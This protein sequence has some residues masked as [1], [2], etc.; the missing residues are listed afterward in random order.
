LS[1]DYDYYTIFKKV[2]NTIVIGILTLLL[3]SYLCDMTMS[4]TIYCILGDTITISLSLLLVLSFLIEVMMTTDLS[5]LKT[6]QIIIFMM[7]LLERD[8]SP[9]RCKRL[10][11]IRCNNDTATTSHHHHYHHERYYYHQKQQQKSVKDRILPLRR[12]QQ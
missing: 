4:R 9:N 5:V 7:S 3:L 12:K 2:G 11:I 1:L 6:A 10:F 8:I